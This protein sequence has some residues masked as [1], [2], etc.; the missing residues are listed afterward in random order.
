M[1]PQIKLIG[2]PH[3]G[4]LEPTRLALALGGIKFEDSC[5]SREQWGE[6]KPKVTPLQMP[7]M[8]IDGKRASQSIA[9]LRYACKLSKVDG[10]PLYPEDAF[11]ALLVDEFVDKVGDMLVPMLHTFSI[12]DESAKIA[13]RAAVMKKGGDVEKWAAHIDEIMGKSKSGYVYFDR[14]TMADVT[15]FSMMWLFQTGFLDGVPKDCLDHLKHTA[16]H[17]KKIASLPAVKEYYKDAK[18]LQTFYKC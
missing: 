9:M 13:R 2:F 12:A 15:I 1:T 7:L 4:R 11:E 10:K 18:D 14:L 3:P 5:I 6:M 8:E 17:K 16:A